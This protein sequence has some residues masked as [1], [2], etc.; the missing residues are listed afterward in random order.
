MGKE[1]TRERARGKGNWNICKWVG[2]M[3]K[4]R[5]EGKQS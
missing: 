1:K 4:G 3:E 2:K 5:V